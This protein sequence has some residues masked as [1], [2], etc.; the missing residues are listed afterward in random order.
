MTT[1]HSVWFWKYPLPIVLSLTELNTINPIYNSVCMCVLVIVFLQSR[2]ISGF[3]YFMKMVSKFTME[4]LKCVSCVSIANDDE[5]IEAHKI[6]LR[7]QSNCG[8]GTML[9]IQTS[10]YRFRKLATDSGILL[11]IQA[12]CYRFRHLATDSGILLIA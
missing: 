6:C 12:S 11:W 2:E 3:R 5:N 4:E 10:C 7:K 9:K 1:S 8:N